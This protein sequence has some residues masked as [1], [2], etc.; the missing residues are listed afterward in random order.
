MLA[1]M[2]NRFMNC[3]RNGSCQPFRRTLAPGRSAWVGDNRSRRGREQYPQAAPETGPQPPSGRDRNALWAATGV[4]RKCYDRKV[5]VARNRRRE[6]GRMK[7][8]ETWD[9][10]GGGQ[11]LGLS[12]VG[13]ILIVVLIVILL[14]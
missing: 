1:A 4:R 3:L 9:A 5:Q 11:K 14:G 10:L 2:E 7:W 6:A 8:G 13:A 12:V